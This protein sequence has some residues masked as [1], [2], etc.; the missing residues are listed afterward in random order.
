MI[1]GM[2]ER[3]GVGFPLGVV[4]LSAEFKPGHWLNLEETYATGGTEF[5]GAQVPLV[6]DTSGVRADVVSSSPLTL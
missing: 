6:P 4:G 2:S 1:L 5:L 3:L